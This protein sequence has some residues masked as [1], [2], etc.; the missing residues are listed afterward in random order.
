MSIIKEFKE[1][2]KWDNNFKMLVHN[3]IKTVLF[4]TAMI[5]TVILSAHWLLWISG[6]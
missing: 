1:A 6:K 2:Y 4:V 3:V 5:I